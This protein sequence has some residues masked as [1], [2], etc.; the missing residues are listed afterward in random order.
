VSWR[1]RRWTGF[2][3]GDATSAAGGGGAGSG[4]RR[5]WARWTGSRS[6]PGQGALDAPHEHVKRRAGVALAEMSGSE[7]A[8]EA[9]NAETAH[10]LVTETEARVGVA[11]H[12]EAQVLHNLPGFINGEDPG[13]EGFAGAARKDA[14]VIGILQ[15]FRKHDIAHVEEGGQLAYQGI[16]DAPRVLEEIGKPGVQDEASP[17]GSG[18]VDGAVSSGSMYRGRGRPGGTISTMPCHVHVANFGPSATLAASLRS[19]LA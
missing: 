3:S 5:V 10:G 15:V 19:Q 12:D 11:A 16:P 13:P 4:T 2:A 1:P 6:T 18:L 7:A 9:V 8:D 14:E 17:R